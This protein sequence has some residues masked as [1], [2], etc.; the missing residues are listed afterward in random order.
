MPMLPSR[1]PAGP[2]TVISTFPYLGPDVTAD[3][4]LPTISEKSNKIAHVS[5]L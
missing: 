3:F 5:H 2:S 4:V 1:W